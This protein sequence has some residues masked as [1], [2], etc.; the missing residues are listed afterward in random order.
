[1][2]SASAALVSAPVAPDIGW[3]EL[4]LAALLILVNAGAS[5][6]F[7][8][9]LG[10]R[11]LVSTV[12]AGLQLA[13]LGLVL[14]WVFE[15]ERWTAVLGLMLAMGVLAGFEAARRTAYRVPG[16]ASTAVVAM[17]SASM[18]VTFYATT[19]VLRVEPWFAPRFV[20]PILGMILG[21][22]MNGVS[23]GLDAALGGFMDKRDT[24]DT[25]LAHGA[26]PEEA[27]RD[28]VRAAVRRGTI[29]ILN[30]MA[31]AGAISIPGM[32]TGQI[33]AG[34]SPARAAAYQAFILFCI[35]GSTALGTVGVVLGSRRLVF[36]ARGRLR[37]DRIRSVS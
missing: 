19:A 27:T 20:L 3:V 34:E 22:G 13:L 14:H 18:L 10:R 28:V 9:G 5:V 31:A 25:L 23:L 4:T 16:L 32:M 33:L 2:G 12:R 6:V 11:L 36:D 15:L 37:A 17:I 26:T 8:L 29:P 1:M 21:N 7:R 24:I 35:A 30:S